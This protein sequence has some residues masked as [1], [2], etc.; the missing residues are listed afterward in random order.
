MVKSVFIGDQLIV[1]VQVEGS[2]WQARIRPTDE[3]PP[4]GGPVILWL[5]PDLCFAFPTE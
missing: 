1:T 5:P 3:L 4:E 2:V